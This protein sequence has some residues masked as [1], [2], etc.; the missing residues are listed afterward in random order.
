[1]AVKC[2]EEYQRWELRVDAIEDSATVTRRQVSLDG[3][4][5][6]EESVEI[7]EKNDLTFPCRD[8]EV[9]AGLVW[10]ID[11]EEGIHFR[12]PRSFEIWEIEK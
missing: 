10:S 7:S 1:M 2:Q 6:G 11:P 3:N 5:T 12:A 4:P 9:V 8:E